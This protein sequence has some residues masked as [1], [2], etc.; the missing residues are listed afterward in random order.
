[1]AIGKT[2]G[3]LSVSSVRRSISRLVP[4]RIRRWRRTSKWER[5]WTERDA[6]GWQVEEVAPEFVHAVEAEWLR[7]GTSVLDVGCG[8]GENAAWLAAHGFVVLG[9]DVSAVA[10]S[11]AKGAH[12]ERE[13]LDFDVVDVTK[14]GV[15]D[16]NFDAV[17][18]RGCLHGIPPQLRQAYAR[19]VKRWVRPDGPLVIT[20]H[21]GSEQ[22]AGVRQRQLEELLAPEFRGEDR[23]ERVRIGE[24]NGQ[25]IWGVTFLLRRVEL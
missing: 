2:P 15:L 4:T 7:A 9:V 23:L 13:N 1:M 3:G 14:T 22:D 20:M 6:F 19:N 17:I 8:A 5:K 12:D 18:D 11:R 16:Q 21:T 25:P 24:K 10:I